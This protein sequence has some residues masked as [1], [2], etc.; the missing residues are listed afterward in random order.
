M[1]SQY[2]QRWKV[3]TSAEVGKA[4]RCTIGTFLWQVNFTASSSAADAFCRVALAIKH[5]SPC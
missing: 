5:F 4:Q 1:C 2:T 3:C